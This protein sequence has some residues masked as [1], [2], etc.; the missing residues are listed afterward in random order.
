MEFSFRCKPETVSKG[1]QKNFAEF[2]KEVG[3]SWV[4]NDT[5]FD[6]TWYRRLVAK[7]IVFR[8]LEKSVPK[9]DWY[10]GGYRANIVT[11][12]IAK[13]VADAEAM[14]LLVDLDAVW[15]AQA[16]PDDLG[17]ALLNAAKSATLTLTQ[18][19]LGIKNTT[20]W[21]KKQ[22]CWE[23]L[24]H[25]KVEYSPSIMQCLVEPEDA[26]AVVK[27]GR[28]EAAIISGIEAQSNVISAGSEFWARLRTWG[29]ATRTL[30]PREE[31]ILKACSATQVRLPSEKQ[32][33]AALHI[34]EK[35]RETGYR[36]ENEAPRVRI[37]GWSR[38]H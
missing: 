21:A 14:S 29:I 12:A 3:D 23:G 16:V 17:T 28:R 22:A 26:R 6:E 11:Y 10:P 38:Q 15:Q 1:A 24:R 4:K 36:D 30:S 9:Q 32:C 35:A 31:G 33:I 27:E 7:L 19:I 20:E 5:R 34:L 8:Y 18:P 37:S 25:R 2:A 13:L